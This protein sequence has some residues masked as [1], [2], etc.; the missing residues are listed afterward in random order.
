MEVLNRR[1]RISTRTMR[2]GW[3]AQAAFVLQF[4]WRDIPVR[5][6]PPRIIQTE[7]SLQGCHNIQI[8]RSRA[9]TQNKKAALRLSGNADA[10]PSIDIEREN[11]E[12]NDPK[13]YCAALPAA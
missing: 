11:S 4:V 13:F 1:A 7:G 10:A 6:P 8:Q 9:E 2:L 3:L 12:R 5:D